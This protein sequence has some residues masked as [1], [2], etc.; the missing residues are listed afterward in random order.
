MKKILSALVAAVVT[1]T[2]FAGSLS[3][4]N[5][6]LS[7]D[8][9][10]REVYRRHAR[11]YAAETDSILNGG[12][13]IQLDKYFDKNLADLIWKDLTTHD[14]DVA[15][16]DF[17][18][19]YDTQDDRISRHTVGRAKI[20]GGRASVPVTFYNFKRRQNLTFKLTLEGGA[21]KISDILY[22]PRD[23]LLK[24]FADYERSEGKNG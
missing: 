24:Y 10:V 21:W 2:A 8:A 23:S 22:G 7:P 16:I 15:V 20:A 19:F 14:D 4:A 18:I 13:R 3:A 17:D 9:V 5:P 11:D 1:I 12:D 6:P